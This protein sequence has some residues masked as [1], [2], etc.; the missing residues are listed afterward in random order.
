MIIELMRPA[1]AD[2]ARRWLAALL[3]APEDER[4]DIV[5]SVEARMHHLYPPTPE[6]SAGGES[7]EVIVKPGLNASRPPV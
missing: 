2:L 5:A 4:E 6:E 3:L 7:P 1:T